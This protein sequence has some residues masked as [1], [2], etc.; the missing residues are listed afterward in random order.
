MFIR[1]LISLMIV[2]L[3]ASAGRAGPFTR[4]PATKPDPAEQVPALLKTLQM[5]PDEN[6]RGDAAEELREFDLKA[7][8]DIMPALIEALKNDPSS[9]VRAEVVNSIGK[10]R[11]ISQPAGYALEQAVAND[12]SLRVRAAAKSQLVHWVAFL[13]Y[14]TSRPNENPSNQTEE[15]PL[16]A[17]LPIESPKSSPLKDKPTANTAPAKSASSTSRP[18]FPLLSRPAKPEKTDGPVLNAPK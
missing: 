15:P 11:P 5:D 18:L 13:G 12:T 16:A 7:F 8:P 6:K 3:S 14:R 1:I 4:K 9:S 2:A 17:P 10:I